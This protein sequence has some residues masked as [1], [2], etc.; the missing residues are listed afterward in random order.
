[1]FLGVLEARNG[2]NLETNVNSLRGVQ[3][4][5]RKP[6]ISNPSEI[7]AADTEGK[8]AIIAARF[9]S[10]AGMLGGGAALVAGALLCTI[11]IP[12]LNIAMG[13]V[14]AIFIL[15]AVSAIIYDCE[16]RETDKNEGLYGLMLEAIADFKNEVKWGVIIS[17]FRE[18]NQQNPSASEKEVYVGDQKAREFIQWL[19]DTEHSQQITCVSKLVD[20]QDANK[21]IRKIG[22]IKWQSV[23]KS[24]GSY[25]VSPQKAEL[26]MKWLLDLQEKKM[27]SPK[28][29]ANLKDWLTKMGI[30]IN[31]PSLPQSGDLQ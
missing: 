8:T 7:K 21:L 3:Q 19:K 24:N 25:S 18:W 17:K 13:V 6:G 5:P 9:F 12:G 16:N 28:E 23:S 14:G 10:E 29:I 15:I 26:F 30:N 31:L 11:P 27:C 1:M 4:D 2:N 20:S 22:R